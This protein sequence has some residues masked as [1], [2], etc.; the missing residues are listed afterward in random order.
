LAAGPVIGGRQIRPPPRRPNKTFPNRFRTNFRG[1]V[2]LPDEQFFLFGM[3]RRTKL[4]FK[5]GALTCAQSSE[6]V[7][8]WNV[9]Q[10]FILPDQYTVVL[11]HEGGDET[12]IVEDERGGLD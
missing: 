2:E 5:A 1:T 7:R 6:V 4:V 8:R 11:R 12:R 9:A 10:E 3:G